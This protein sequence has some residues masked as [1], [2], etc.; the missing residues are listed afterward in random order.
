MPHKIVYS[1]LN[2]K[3]LNEKYKKYIRQEHV[4]VV[5]YNHLGMHYVRVYLFA[6][7][8]FKKSFSYQLYTDIII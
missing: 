7:P 6:N 8:I 1:R 3:L 4:Y 5:T 2:V